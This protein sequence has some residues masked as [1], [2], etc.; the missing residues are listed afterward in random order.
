[1]H[2][3]TQS[4][5]NL[6]NDTAIRIIFLF[7]EGIDIKRFFFPYNFAIHDFYSPCSEFKI[8]N[9]GQCKFFYAIETIK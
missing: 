4:I 6:F 1:M 8:L 7:L 9:H 2:V 5:I 3:H